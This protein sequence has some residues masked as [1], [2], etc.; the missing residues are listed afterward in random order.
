M[1]AFTISV[2][3]QLT[4]MFTFSLL[5]VYGIN[6][7]SHFINNFLDNTSAFS[8]MSHWMIAFAVKC[9]CDIVKNNFI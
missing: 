4:Q 3:F 9:P 5:F 6:L 8:L 7:A 2:P 1:F